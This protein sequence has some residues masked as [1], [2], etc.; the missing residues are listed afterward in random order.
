MLDPHGHLPFQLESLPDG[1][2]SVR[3]QDLT[4]LQFQSS[5]TSAFIGADI[6]PSIALADVLRWGAPFALA[7]SGSFLLHAACVA[8]ER[9]AIALVAPGGTGKSTLG[10]TLT[11]AGWLRVSDDALLCGPGGHVDGEAEIILREWCRKH[12]AESKRGGE[13]NFETLT[14]ALSGISSVSTRQAELAA[15]V[16]LELPRTHNGRF[17]SRRLSSITG[18]HQLVQHGFGSRPTRAI[19]QDE[20]RLYGALASSVPLWCVRVP[21]GLEAMRSAVSEWLPA[22]MS[23]PMPSPQPMPATLRTERR[24]SAPGT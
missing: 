1:S 11:R 23:G 10:H 19:W 7:R 9:R 5:G 3:W 8:H 22:I 2:F 12:A 15:I 4:L 20:A 13:V 17:A 21:E 18:F 16:F 14:E 6:P 24:G